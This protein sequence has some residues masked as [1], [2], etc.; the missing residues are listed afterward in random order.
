MALIEGALAS[1]HLVLDLNTWELCSMTRT[2][3]PGLLLID[4]GEGRSEN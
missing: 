4:I 3:R 1:K 2:A